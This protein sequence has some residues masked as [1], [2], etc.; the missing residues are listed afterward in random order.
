MDLVRV[1]P[2]SYRATAAASAA[3]AAAVVVVRRQVLRINR[4]KSIAICTFQSINSIGT[5]HLS[6]A[7]RLELYTVEHSETRSMLLSKSFTMVPANLCVASL[8]LS[9]MAGIVHCAAPLDVATAD[10]THS[11][12]RVID[13][14]NV[15]KL[16]GWSSEKVG[17]RSKT[18]YYMI[19]ELAEYGNLLSL[20]ERNPRFA[21]RQLFNWSL[22]IVAGLIEIHNK[23]GVHRDLKLNNILVCCLLGWVVAL[24]RWIVGLLLA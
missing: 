5:K 7:V 3:A 9:G 10:P 18:L 4:W 20:I 11:T 17:R 14:P 21:D 2:T 16:Y 13:H 1:M 6:A 15:V 24:D 12:H 19:C 8:K 23:F 22:Q